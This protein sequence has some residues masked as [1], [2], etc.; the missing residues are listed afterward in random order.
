MD[1][2][3]EN[4]IKRFDDLDGQKGTYRSHLQEIAEFMIP[5]LASITIGRTLGDKRTTKLFSGIA[6]RALQTWTNGLYGHLTSPGSPWYALTVKDKGLLKQW[7]VSSWL[8]DTS[9]RMM[10]GLNASN[11]GMAIQDVYRNIGAFGTPIVYLE[12]GKRESIL[13][14]K[15][16]NSGNVAI[17][18]NS[19]GI[20]DTVI[21]P[22][23]FTARQC[24]QEWGMDVISDA[25]R[26]AFEDKKSDKFTIL[27][28]VFPR[29]EF[30][31]KKRDERNMPYASY[32]IEKETGNILSESGYKEFP[33]M[34]P[35]M[36]RDPQ[37]LYGRGIGMDVLADVKSYNL[38]RK[39]DLVAHEKSS[40]PPILAP[41]EMQMMPLRTKPGAISF[42]KGPKPPEFWNQPPPASFTFEDKQEIRKDI[43]DAFFVDLFNL[44]A[45]GSNVKT[46]YEVSQIME[47]KLMLLGPMLGFFKPD[48]FD[49]LLRRVF[50]IMYRAGYIAPPPEILVNQGLEVEYISKLAM[51]MR[52]F[53]T[54]AMNKTMTIVGPLIQVVPGILDNF[55]FDNFARGTAERSGVPTDWLNSEDE[56]KKTRQAR[57]QANAE[58][59][60]KAEEQQMAE[61]LTKAGPSLLKAPEQGSMMNDM[62]GLGGGQNGTA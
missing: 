49:P 18:E 31:Q 21:V 39:S 12:E 4:I 11:F 16:Y 17:D 15:T 5:S 35:R 56:V 25:I 62:T 53:E 3:A 27:H 22:E 59:Q 50:W 40:N 45:N 61:T 29:E 37:E 52:S 58:A 23:K 42:Y 51:A 28:S 46:A 33:F 8:A 6:T 1:Q 54:Q 36:N 26:K 47:E 38:I 24:V 20:I 60:K 32:W 48:L 41:N 57:A 10:D 34:V 2:I 30:E 13:N 43:Q 7:D 9:S 44:L 14:F 19:Q 55:N